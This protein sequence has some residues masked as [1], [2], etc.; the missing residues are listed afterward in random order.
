MTVTDDPTATR[1]AGDDQPCS[2]Q[3]RGTAL[4]SGREITPTGLHYVR[5]NFPLPTH[6][7]TLEIFGAVGNRLSSPSRTCGRCRHSSTR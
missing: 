4:R 2:L 6:D 3:R 5:S 1:C 7:G